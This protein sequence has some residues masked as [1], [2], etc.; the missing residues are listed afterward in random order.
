[1]AGLLS[2]QWN[3]RRDDAWALGRRTNAMLHVVYKCDVT[4]VPRGR[5]GTWSSRLVAISVTWHGCTIMRRS[6]SRQRPLGIFVGPGSTHLSTLCFTGKT[7]AVAH[8]ASSP[9][10]QLEKRRPGTYCHYVSAHALA[11]TYRIRI[12]YAYTYTMSKS[13]RICDSVLS[14]THYVA[15]FSRESLASDLANRSARLPMSQWLLRMVCPC[16]FAYLAKT[17]LLRAERFTER[18]TS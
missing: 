16:S 7:A 3:T 1:M 13:C 2:E 9:G 14:R 17:N 11:I 5:S 4:K 6:E 15:L 10:R 12:R 18:F 8:L